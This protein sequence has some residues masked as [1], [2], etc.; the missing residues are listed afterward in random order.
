[1]FTRV[2]LLAAAAALAAGSGRVVEVDVGT[3]GAVS[4]HAHQQPQT[5]ACAAPANPVVAENCKPGSES[6]EWDVN[7]GGDPSIR[8]F[9]TR[10][11][12]NVGETVRFKV[13]TDAT[14][15]SRPFP[16]GSDGMFSSGGMYLVLRLRSWWSWHRIGRVGGPW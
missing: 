8:G 5:D 14:V 11:S 2:L 15:R 16:S 9:A 4:W 3:T 13:K 10:F 6:S 1:M 7:A 12:S